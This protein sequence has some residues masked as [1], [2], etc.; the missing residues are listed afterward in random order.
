M[1]LVSDDLLIYSFGGVSFARGGFSYGDAGWPTREAVRVIDDVLDSS[2]PYRDFGGTHIQ[3][4]AVT[5]AFDSRAARDSV[6]AKVG[7]TG[8]LSKSSTGQG[9]TV[10]L[11]S[12]SE[13]LL[14]AGLPGAALTFE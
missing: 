12:A 1:A 11:T 5:A 2:T 14:A 10:M 4:F 9:V 3:P 6:V 8:T 7:T 13:V